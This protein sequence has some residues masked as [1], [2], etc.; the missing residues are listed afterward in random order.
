VKAHI[1]RKGIL[2]ADTAVARQ[3]AQGH[4]CTTAQHIT[5][6]THPV[7][8]GAGTSSCAFTAASNRFM[9]PT[10]TLCSTADDPPSPP[11]PPGPGAAAAAAAAAWK[12]CARCKALPRALSSAPV[13]ESMRCRSSCRREA[14]AVGDSTGAKNRGQHNTH[15][16][17]STADHRYTAEGTQHRGYT[18]QRVRMTGHRN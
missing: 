11:P 14:T 17:S 5:S 9:V 13:S 18:A 6:T 16:G 1:M 10:S 3:Q 2:I 15:H 8:A 7:R 4:N 12:V